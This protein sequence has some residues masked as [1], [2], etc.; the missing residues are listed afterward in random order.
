MKA[1]RLFL[2]AFVFSSTAGAAT[3][4]TLK[5][6]EPIPAPADSSHYAAVSSGTVHG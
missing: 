1:A 5:K 4:Q 6:P 2:L 3:L